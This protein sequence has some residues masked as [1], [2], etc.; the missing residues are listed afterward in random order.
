MCMIGNAYVHTLLPPRLGL[1]RVGRKMRSV[2]GGMKK[3][4]QTAQ[5]N[6]VR[7]LLAENISDAYWHNVRVSTFAYI[8]RRHTL[9]GL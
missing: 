9:Q 2:S 6:S 3:L 8:A 7:K 4:A 1:N 5:L